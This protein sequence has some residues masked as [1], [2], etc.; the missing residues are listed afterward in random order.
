MFGYRGVGLWLSRFGFHWG[1]GPGKASDD[2]RGSH[3]DRGEDSEG[4]QVSKGSSPVQGE[5]T[6]IREF[7]LQEG[8]L[9]PP[10]EFGIWGSMPR[11]PNDSY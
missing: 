3:T 11:M 5:V 6:E 1:F 7:I 4:T 8:W 10:E 9:R 2:S